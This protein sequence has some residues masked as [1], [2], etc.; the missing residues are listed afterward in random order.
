MVLTA[1]LEM[2]AMSRA[3]A[4][5]FVFLLDSVAST[6]LVQPAKEIGF[7]ESRTQDSQQ[8]EMTTRV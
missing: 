6:V 4:N 7:D 3:Q 2:G 8:I 5:I 1:F